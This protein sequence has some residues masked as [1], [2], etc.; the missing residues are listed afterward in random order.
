ML[1]YFSNHYDCNRGRYM[2]AFTNTVKEAFYEKIFTGAEKSKS[3]R[4]AQIFGC[5][6]IL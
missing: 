1:C 2:A 5:F 4:Y 3:K 6:V